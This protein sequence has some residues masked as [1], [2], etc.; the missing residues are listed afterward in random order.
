MRI[1]MPAFCMSA[2]IAS[3]TPGYWIFTATARPS[4]ST[5][6]CTCPIEAA[7]DGL[8]VEAL[9]QLLRR[10]VPLGAQHALH[11]LPRHRRRRGAQRGQLLLVELAV[12]RGKE[13][14]VDE[15]GELADLHRR[16][17]HPAQR[18]HHPLRGLE[19]A[20]LQRLGTR[21]RGAGQVGRAGAGVAGALGAENRSHLRRAAHPAGRN[22]SVV[23][24]GHAQV[25]IGRQ[26]P[27]ATLARRMADSK[28]PTLSVDERP[29]HGSRAVRR[30]RRTGLVP[31]IVY[32]GTDG[33]C[34]SFKVDSRVL[35]KVLVDGSALIDLE[36]GGHEDPAGDRE[37]PAAAPGSRRRDAH[38]PARGAAGREDPGAG[39][40]P[41]R[42]RGGRARREGGRRDGAGRPPA[43]DRG[44]AHR[45][46]RLHHRRR[47][48]DGDRGHD[49][50]LGADPARG[51]R[52]PR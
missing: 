42:G 21:V 10:L 43:P 34:V 20:A 19:M 13:L 28:R 7:A 47:L 50:P 25:R 17:L 2:R 27:P 52:V 26:P 15:G 40:R 37:G 41:H 35:R 14:G 1:S 45:H 51:R 32:G 46:S 23:V 30:L 36:I 39:G 31:G 18:L 29:E 4:H 48:R 16:A 12:L 11:L 5:A 22:R 3:A 8:P 38:R 9:E 24:L 33:D 49:A 6:R 44:A